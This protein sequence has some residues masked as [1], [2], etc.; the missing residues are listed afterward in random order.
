M[1]INFEIES[2]HD[3]TFFIATYYTIIFEPSVFLI[4]QKT[5]FLIKMID[6]NKIDVFK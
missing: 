2:I 3:V 4:S 6:V 5:T 1:R